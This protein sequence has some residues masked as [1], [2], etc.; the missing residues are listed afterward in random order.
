MKAKLC[1]KQAA[2]K[3]VLLLGFFSLIQALQSHHRQRLHTHLHGDLDGDDGQLD[4]GGLED[5]Q[6]SELPYR[7]IVEYSEELKDSSSGRV[8][9]QQAADEAPQ[10]T[11]T[12]TQPDQNERI[13]TTTPKVQSKPSNSTQS[14]VQMEPPKVQINQAQTNATASVNVTNSTVVQQDTATNS[15]SASIQVAPPK[16]VDSQSNQNV[17]KQK[18]GNTTQATVETKEHS[19]ESAHTEPKKGPEQKANSTQSAAE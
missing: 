18:Q 19:N 15:S 6:H 1:N 13:H 16:Q 17:T 10:S 5:S 8:A 3:I 4:D 7:D 11:P 14:M 12:L 9:Q 2:F